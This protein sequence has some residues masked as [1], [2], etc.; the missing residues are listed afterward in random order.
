LEGL[1]TIP[2][3]EVAFVI[4]DT[5]T[6]ACPLPSFA[7]ITALLFAVT[8]GV[9]QS[10]VQAFPLFVGVVKLPPI[11]EVNVQFGFGVTP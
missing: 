4:T 9:A 6:D 7:V 2:P 5:V 1:E 11:E 8:I 3:L 10:S